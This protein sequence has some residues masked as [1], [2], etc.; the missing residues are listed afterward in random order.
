[1]NDADRPTVRDQ[2][3]NQFILSDADIELWRA[4]E[5]GS[6]FPSVN[7]Y[8]WLIWP[9]DRVDEAT[10]RPHAEPCEVRDGQLFLIHTQFNQRGS[11]EHGFT[12]LPLYSQPDV[13]RLSNYLN[14]T[15]WCPNTPDYCPECQT[16]LAA[17]PEAALWI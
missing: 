8:Y 16:A 1:M 7:G 6:A 3:R 2:L 9:N 14:H 10:G 12:F 11:H 17:I 15:L 5:S 13:A 4:R